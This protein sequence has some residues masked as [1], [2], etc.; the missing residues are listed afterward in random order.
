MNELDST[1][2]DNDNHHSIFKEHWPRTWTWT[3]VIVVHIDEF[4]F[5]ISNRWWS[6]SILSIDIEKFNHRS[7]TNLSLTCWSYACHCSRLNSFIIDMNMSCNVRNVRLY[8]FVGTSKGI[9]ECQHQFY[10]RHWNCSI[11]RDGSVFGPVLYH[12]RIVCVLWSYV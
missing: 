9:E 1:M 3:Y 5:S 8:F 7:K 12:G 2:I 4:G 11:V 10:D 6:I